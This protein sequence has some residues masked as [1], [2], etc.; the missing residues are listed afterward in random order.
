VFA[1]A[2]GCH[3]FWHI[4][5]FERATKLSNESISRARAL[6]EPFTLAIA[7][8]YAAMLHQ[9]DHNNVVTQ[10][11]SEEAIE[12]CTEHQ[13]AYYL[14]WARMIHGWTIVYTGDIQTGMAEMHKGLDDFRET[15]AGLRLPYYLSL[16]A[17]VEGLAGQPEKALITVGQ[18]LQSSNS[19]GEKW[20]NADLLRLRA[21]LLMQMN[22]DKTNDAETAFQEALKIAR[23]QGGKARELQISCELGRLWHSQGKQREA[24]DLVADICGHFP[25]SVDSLWVK[26]AKALLGEIS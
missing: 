4:G 3:A 18:A 10:K 2:F 22:S 8:N 12:L 19:N 11:L 9:F 5:E 13:F 6:E 17:E 20:H 24:G 25:D 7:L 14:A 16:L 26:N 1:R 21:Q 15:G 23:E